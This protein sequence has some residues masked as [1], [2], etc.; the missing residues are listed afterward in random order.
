MAAEKARSKLS[1]PL[2][3]PYCHSLETKFRYFNNYDVN[4]PRHCCKNCNRWWTRGIFRHKRA[5]RKNASKLLQVQ[6]PEGKIENAKES[7]N[8]TRISSFNDET[9][10][11]SS[12]SGVA[13]ID[14]NVPY[15]EETDGANAGDFVNSL[16]TDVSGTVFS[17]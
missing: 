13:G 17:I 6:E 4:Q 1:M 14:L 3:C 12:V 11:V 16:T 9:A 15:L 10:R 7:I 2:P 5:S 8:E